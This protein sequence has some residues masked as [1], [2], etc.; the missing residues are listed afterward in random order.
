MKHIQMAQDVD[1]LIVGDFNLLRGPNN[2]NKPGG[3]VQEMLLFN[4]VISA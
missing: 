2:I 4:E 1:W 3:I